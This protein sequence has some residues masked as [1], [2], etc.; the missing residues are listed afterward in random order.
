[1]IA[2]ITHRPAR[3][4]GGDR[5][6]VATL[7][8]VLLGSGALLGIGAMVVDV[9]Q[10]YA[11]REELQ[12]GA[13]AAALAAAQE[14]SAGRCA[15]GRLTTLAG[16]YAGKNAADGLADA[17]LCGY[18]AKARALSDCPAPAT[19]LTR[20]AGDRPATGKNYVEVTTSTRSKTNT[21]LPPTFAG[22]LMGKDYR[23]S[24]VAACA[25]A[26]WGGPAKLRA[27]GMGV[28]ECA[29]RNLT[30]NGTDYS[31]LPIKVPFFP[32]EP[33]NPGEDAIFANLSACRGDASSAGGSFSWLGGSAGR[34][35]TDVATG[36]EVTGIS[37]NDWT[38]LFQE[39]PCRWDRV[40][41]WLGDLWSSRP[42]VIY[43]PVYDS[44]KS[45]GGGKFSY[46]ISG[47]AAFVPTGYN[48]PGLTKTP[49]WNQLILGGCWNLF[50]GESGYCMS[51][52]F[53]RK[54]ISGPVGNDADYGVG[55]VDL[56]G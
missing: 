9:G 34:C 55:A 7:V 14:C 21:L 16:S 8:A 2:W 15:P 54:L 56:T 3:R 49:S 10:L 5:G 30:K 47:Y 22:A 23:G 28:S 38:A 35:Q 24:T 18:D 27:L 13:D 53:V 33:P 26:R 52:F 19:N 29:W 32:L 20:C 39:F 17:A 1:M 46:H 12:N 41:G 31:E 4:D 48:F 25:R 50:G 40:L 11:E 44:S 6:A 37:G 51:G 43:L 42:E 36:S 45:L